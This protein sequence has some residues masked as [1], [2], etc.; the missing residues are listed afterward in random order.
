VAVVI[1]KIL[2]ASKDPLVPRY[3]YDLIQLVLHCVKF[4]LLLLPHRGLQAILVLK[5]LLEK[6]V[7]RDPKVM[8]ES[9]VTMVNKEK[10]GLKASLDGV[11]TSQDLL[12]VL[13][14]KEIK[15]YQEFRALMVKM[16]LLD[17]L[18]KKEN[19]AKLHHLA[20]QVN[21]ANQENLVKMV[22]QE[23]QES[24]VV[25]DRRAKLLDWKDLKIR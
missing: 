9:L 25:R 16:A 5:D 10:R 23:N 22:N 12:V 24:L 4:E 20:N 3:D 11:L 6:Q 2:R 14:K 18:V 21:L 1:L 15:E 19:A 8:M 17:H 13:E 7:L